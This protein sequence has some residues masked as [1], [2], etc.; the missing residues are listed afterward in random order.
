MYD[1]IIVGAG[2]SGMTAALYGRRANKKV[3]VLEALTYGGQI[4]NANRI[5]NYP[6]LPNI[7][8]VDFA[9]NLY[10]QIIELGAEVKFEKVIN[11]EYPNVITNENTYIA[12]AIIIATGAEKRK[13]GL[14]KEDYYN[15]RGLSYCATCDGNFYKDMDV[16]VY[17]SGNTALDDAMYLSNISKKV[18]LITHGNQFKGNELTLKELEEKE[19]VQIIYN[20]SITGLH[21]NEKLESIEIK[22]P[23]ETKELNISGLFVAIG[24]VPETENFINILDLNEKGYAITNDNRTKIKGIYVCGDVVDKRLRQLA[25]AIGDGANAAT[26]AIQ[27]INSKII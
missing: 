9:T 1:I 19:N 18:Y 4:I 26:V 10:N 24:Q 21:G 7:S 22:N 23:L 6:G 11:I 20:T 8:G 16:C 17:G 12:K 13:L 27:D 25:T 15:G 3:L 5:D 2:P 14:E